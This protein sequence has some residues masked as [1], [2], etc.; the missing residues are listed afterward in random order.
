MLTAVLY[1]VGIFALFL[2]FNI[3]I[4]VKTF[5]LYRQLLERRIQFGLADLLSNRRWLDILKLYPE[6][7]S[8]LNHFRRHM[9]MT[10]ILFLLVVVAVIVLLFNMREIQA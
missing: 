10:G 6:H 1:I 5:K 9:L 8:L 4:R 3:Y 7:A 2:A